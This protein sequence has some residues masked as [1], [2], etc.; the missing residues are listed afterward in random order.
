M[1]KNSISIYRKLKKSTKWIALA[2]AIAF[3]GIAS[4]NYAE[5]CAPSSVIG[6]WSGLHTAKKGGD[7]VA[8]VDISSLSE[9][10]KKQ[11]RQL[12]DLEVVKAQ[13]LYKFVYTKDESTSPI[14]SDGT[15]IPGVGDKTPNV[16]DKIP[17]VG[18]KT[19]NTVKEAIH[20]LLPNTGT[21][22]LSAYGA[23]FGFGILA[24]AS[25][26]IVSNKG[27]KSRKALLLFLI[28]GGVLGYHISSI[29]AYSGNPLAPTVFVT[30][31][32][33][34]QPENIPGYRYVG[35]IEVKI[36]CNSDSTPTPDPVPTPDPD[37]DPAPTPVP[38]QK[39]GTVIV[40]YL[41]TEGNEIAPSET[42]ASDLV[43]GTGYTT[44]K[45]DISGYT[46]KEMGTD[47]A[48]ANG[49]VVEGTKTVIYVYKK[50]K[51]GTY[52]LYITG[53]KASLL[54]RE[55]YE[56]VPISYK[57]KGE[58]I[59]PDENGRVL[60]VEKT[61]LVGEN[62]ERPYAVDKETFYKNFSVVIEGKD[63]SLDEYEIMNT[64]DKWG[65]EYRFGTG[66]YGYAKENSQITYIDGVVDDIYVLGDYPL[67]HL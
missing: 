22:E 3:F 61:G 20:N 21:A 25:F 36:L 1:L 42:V 16:G 24:G 51:M 67:D 59:V 39:K 49:E 53:L 10:E 33:Q 56:L 5:E 54:S 29:D 57:W 8:F 52:R 27:K 34:L 63:Y 19:Q 12:E 50:A 7:N 48:P 32:S 60:L 45:K 28:S 31:G 6:D 58:L 2:I 35:I 40:T 4:T 46:F 17:D 18:D 62:I 65:S 38:E 14:P 9:G 43:V 66:L 44:E 64:I 37:P 26:L 13:S 41:D 23:L 55:T 11:I 47:S 15:K 30:E